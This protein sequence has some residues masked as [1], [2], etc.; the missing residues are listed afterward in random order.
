M[1]RKNKLPDFEQISKD[2]Q[3]ALEALP[4]EI[5]SKAEEFINDS[6]ENQKYS[7]DSSS[8]KWQKRK[9]EDKGSTSTRP[10]LTSKG[11]GE[12]LISSFA[13]TITK[14]GVEI[15]N[16]KIYTAIHNEGGEIPKRNGDGSFTMP[17]RQFA[18]I[19]DQEWKAMD[20]MVD[21]WITKNIDPK[22]K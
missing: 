12:K 7:G 5:G 4:H 8:S 2:I 21:E 22:I 20:D 15:T 16:P 10:L 11:S 18:P 17:Q 6:F 1:V 14:N 9:K 3:T 19:E 13:Y